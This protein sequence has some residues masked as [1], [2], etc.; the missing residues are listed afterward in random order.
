MFIRS[1]VVRDRTYYQAI[2]SYREAGPV[3]HRTLASLGTHPTIEEARAAALKEY[4]ALPRGRTFRDVMLNAACTD[5]WNRVL[6]LDDLARRWHSQNGTAYQEDAAV[7]ETRQEREVEQQKKHEA[8]KK[9]QQRYERDAPRRKAKQEAKDREWDARWAELH[10]HLR[11][12]EQVY[13]DLVALGLL[14]TPEEV[15]DAYRRK[16][17]ECHPDHGG[18]D[19]AMVQAV[20]AYERLLSCVTTPELFRR[21]DDAGSPGREEETQR[22]GHRKAIGRRPG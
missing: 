2:E 20:D 11:A 15:R 14:P 9:Q 21:R 7:E 13:R 12:R 22:Q 8:W 19:E 16:A 1:K 5:A 18:T 4:R 6:L 10:E 17:R 3:R